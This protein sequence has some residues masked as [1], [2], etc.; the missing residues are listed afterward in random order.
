MKI[1]IG[2][3][4]KTAELCEQRNSLHSVLS[5]SFS[6]QSIKCHLETKSLLMVWCAAMANNCHTNQFLTITFLHLQLSKFCCWICGQWC[7]HVK[8]SQFS[9]VVPM[10]VK[11]Q[12]ESTTS[13]KDMNKTRCTTF[14]VS[15]N[16]RHFNC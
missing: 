2:L 10:G 6:Q 4:S 15:D 5:S 9:F 8:H 16:C 1:S 7:K 12:K 13:L 3:A 11:M 14:H